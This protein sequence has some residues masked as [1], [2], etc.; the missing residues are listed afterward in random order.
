MVPSH[1]P[2]RGYRG[3]GMQQWIHHKRS[4]CVIDPETF[5]Y[6][7][8]HCLRH[9]TTDDV[10]TILW[11]DIRP[12]NR[13]NVQHSAAWGITGFA[14]AWVYWSISLPWYTDAV[15]MEL[16]RGEF[17][18]RMVFLKKGVDEIWATKARDAVFNVMTEKGSFPTQ[19]RVPCSAIAQIVQVNIMAGKRRLHIL[20]DY[21]ES[22]VVSTIPWSALDCQPQTADHKSIHPPRTPMSELAVTCGGCKSKLQPGL[23]RCT[24]CKA[25]FK[26]W[27]RRDP[28][29]S[30]RQ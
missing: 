10:E 3:A 11:K 5:W 1:Q 13:A 25:G 28:R 26:L 20:W 6:E 21:R 9:P 2:V 8:C 19:E 22:E 29:G 15:E 27:P 14:C 18:H 30:Q 16:G 12:G 17:G 7:A 23:L 24:R 4:G